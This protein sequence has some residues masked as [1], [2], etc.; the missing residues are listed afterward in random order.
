MSKF[1]RYLLS[2]LL[3]LFG[4]FALVLVA[5]YW[6]NRAVGLFDR[7]IGDGHSMLIFLEIS[8]LTL[9]NVI[10]IVLPVA[11]FV[12]TVFLTNRLTQDSELV[13]MQA[14]GFSPFR[15]ARPVI[16]FGLVV[17]LFMA[18]LTNLIVPESRATLSAR[19]AALNENITARFMKEGQ[20]LHPDEGLTLYIREITDQGELR[21]LFLSDERGT[22]DRVIYTAKSAILARGETGPKIVMFDGMVQRVDAARKISVT[23]FADFTYALDGL[24]GQHGAEARDIEAMHTPDLLAL[25]LTDRTAMGVT[26]ARFL[27]EVH[28]RLS[29]PLLALGAALVGFAALLLGAFSR[30][31]LWRQIAGAVVILI[32]MQLVNTLANARAMADAAVWPLLYGAPLLGIVAG[33]AMLWF[34]GRRRRAPRAP[35]GMA[36]A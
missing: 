9:P 8:A 33:M 14:T 4:F 19:Q 2:Q 1:D 24:V 18:L 7:I 34:A 28:S 13:V 11:A 5:V 30:F 10:R 17:T 35:S 32:A 31:G 3:A 36:A 22:S 15:L 21:D 20:F 12:A 25:S 27:Q 16:V 6:V 23:R 29:Q 26:P